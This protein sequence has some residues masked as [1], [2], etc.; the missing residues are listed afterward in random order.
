MKTKENVHS[1]RHNPFDGFHSFTAY[2]RMGVIGLLVLV[3]LIFFWMISSYLKTSVALLYV[4]FDIAAL[5]TV[6]TMINRHDSSAYRIAWIVVVL[7]LPVFGLLLY[8]A[9]GRVNFDKREGGRIR[10]SFAA[11]FKNLPLNTKAKEQLAFHYPHC[12]IYA[13]SLESNQYPVFNNTGVTYFSTGES[14]FEQL[15]ADLESAE[16]FIFLEYF[17]VATGRLWNRIHEIL[18]KKI[19]AGV[20]VR[21]MYDDVGCFFKLPS[22]FDKQ[23]RAEGFKIGIFNP[24]FRFIS[25]F[26]MNYRNHQKIAVIDGIIGYT[27]GVNIADEYA[28]IITRFG[29]WKDVGIR[30]EGSAVRTL[31]VVFLQMWGIG[32]R[33]LDECFADYLLEQPVSSQGYVQPYA[34]GPSNNPKNPALDLVR[35]AIGGARKYLW[36]TSPYL[37]LDHEL[38]SDFCL[39]ARGGVD[40]RI[41]V[42]AI[43][44]HYYVGVVNQENYSILIQSGVHIYEYTPGFIHAKLM[45]FDD[46]CATVGSVNLDYRSLYLHYEDGI[47]LCGCPA[48]FDIKRDIEKTM[49]LSHEIT[50]DDV[51]NRPWRRKTAGA[52]FNLFSP[53]M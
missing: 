6:F 20:E 34:D 46:V 29:H 38:I 9:W 10:Q 3:Q 4:L 52:L 30:L 25:D 47:F 50:L 37:V 18:L 27:G 32:V 44:D 51:K 42:P 2:L 16:K 23:L 22:G 33:K 35:Q 21:L 53:L 41:I 13:T 26:Y 12:T 14:Y 17:I 15:T 49:A 31:T 24:A 1:S 43:H 11:G 8:S 7:I 19:K 5:I 45:V 28:N 39:A 36:L 48:V 40:T